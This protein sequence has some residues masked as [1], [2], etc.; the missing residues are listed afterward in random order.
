MI[1]ERPSNDVV[2]RDGGWVW[3]GRYYVWER[4]GWVRPA[5][6]LRFAP[7]QLRYEKNGQAMF[8]PGTWVNA[9]GEAT[10]PPPIL[11]P[12]NTPPNESTAEFQTGR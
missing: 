9:K 8:A 2:W 11:V 5:P 6:G 12:A 10:R 1:P 4:G 3:R 7:W